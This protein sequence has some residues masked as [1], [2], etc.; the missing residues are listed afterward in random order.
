MSTT[1]DTFTLPDRASSAS[2]L[3]SSLV[4]IATDM[5]NCCCADNAQNLPMVA[6]S[7]A[8]TSTRVPIA[9]ETS[10]VGTQMPSRVQFRSTER[11][12]RLPGVIETIKKTQQVA[13]T[14][15]LSANLH[16]TSTPS[17]TEPVHLAATSQNRACN[18][19]IERLNKRHFQSQETMH[20]KSI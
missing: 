6:A 17:I 20:V 5:S 8:S 13:S 3:G 2:L 1:P 18:L 4:P 14:K 16:I 19:V 10:N 12:F 15:E 7:Q 11:P 9:S